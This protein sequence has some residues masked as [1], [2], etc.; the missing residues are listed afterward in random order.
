MI[1]PRGASCPWRQGIVG[2]TLR[3][4]LVPA[5]HGVAAKPAR[6]H[7]ELDASSRQREVANAPMI[8]TV[9]AAGD[10]T[11]GGAHSEIL[12][13]ADRDCH[14]AGIMDRRHG[15]MMIPRIGPLGATALLAA[16]SNYACM[17]P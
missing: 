6:Y 9:N 15:L 13:S 14:C 3:E 10:G 4:D 17:V 11:A 12:R 16:A 1:E 7:Q 2:E 5:Q 8:A